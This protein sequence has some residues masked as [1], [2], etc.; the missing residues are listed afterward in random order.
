MASVSS[1]TKDPDAV[2]D[3]AVDWSSWLGEDTIESST[4]ESPSG[5]VKDSDSHDGTVV[6]VWVSG[7]ERVGATYALTNRIVTA[8]GRTDERTIYVTVEEK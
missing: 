2:L 1:F 3:Y 6:R 5:I 4:W 8:G 7:G